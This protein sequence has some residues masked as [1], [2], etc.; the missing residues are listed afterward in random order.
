M[1]STS[2]YPRPQHLGRATKAACVCGVLPSYSF[3]SCDVWM[4]NC[5]LLA[6][7][8]ARLLI[9]CQGQSGSDVPQGLLP[10]TPGWGSSWPH[11]VVD[12]QLYGIVTPLYQH[13]LIGLPRHSVGEWRADAW[14]GAGPQPQADGEGIQLGQR[15]LDLAV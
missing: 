5:L 10:W 8:R 3:H 12:K 7:P 15:L 1:L 11:L 13:N 14:R 2:R 4:F 9:G 6:R